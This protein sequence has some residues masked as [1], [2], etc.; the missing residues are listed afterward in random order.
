MTPPTPIAVLPTAPGVSAPVESSG[1]PSGRTVRPAD[2]RAPDAAREAGAAAESCIIA[3]I[4]RQPGPEAADVADPPRGYETAK[5]VLDV[6]LAGVALMV[7]APILAVAAAAIRLTSPGPVLFRQQRAGRSRR[8][9]TMY[10][11][12][13]MYVGADD[14]KELFRPLNEL[15]GGPCF[16]I[17]HDPRVTGVGRWL[18]KTSIDELPQLWNVLRGEM[19]LVGPRPLPL[20]EV[21]GD[22]GAQDRRHSVRPGLTCL[23]QVSGRTEIPYDEWL[24]LDLWYVRHRR[25][26]LDLAILLRTIPAVLS[27]RGAY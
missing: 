11:L 6:L 25:I 21:R 5:R 27:C 19:S 10:K 9:F 3:R 22:D 13:T 26:G 2:R 14:D 7:A 15:G 12:R 18:R 16:K 8:P 24:A 4:A 23:W 1:G 20:D 17:R